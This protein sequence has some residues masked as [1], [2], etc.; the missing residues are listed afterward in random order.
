ML[1][2]CAGRARKTWTTFI[3]LC[4]HVE[5]IRTSKIVWTLRKD[6]GHCHQDHRAQSLATATTVTHR[7]EKQECSRGSSWKICSQPQTLFHFE[8]DVAT[9]IYT[10][11]YNGN[12]EPQQIDYILSFDDSLRSRT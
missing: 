2:M 1:L 7:V 10:W 5:E 6:W 3:R 11:S 9:N 8:D 12:H 4:H